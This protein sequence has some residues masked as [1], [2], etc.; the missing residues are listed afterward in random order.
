[1][2]A[3]PIP[4]TV[5]ELYFGDVK[6]STIKTKPVGRIEIRTLLVTD[7]KR[8]SGYK[9]IRE[10]LLL[11]EQMYVVCPAIEESE[12]FKS[13]KIEYEKDK[14]KYIKSLEKCYMVNLKRKRMKLLVTLET[15]KL[16]YLFQHS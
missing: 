15:E 7:E 3:T 14:R 4:R 10:K 12:E 9:W 1:M 2:S 13:V 8:E 16:I 6:V 5:A 11:K